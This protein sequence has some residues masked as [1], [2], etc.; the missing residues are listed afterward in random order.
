MQQAPPGRGACVVQSGFSDAR[1]ASL[2]P[3]DAGAQALSLSSEIAQARAPSSPP[4]PIIKVALRNATL[5]ARDDG[6]AAA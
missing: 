2:Q 3:T 6:S 4:D 1:E 5:A